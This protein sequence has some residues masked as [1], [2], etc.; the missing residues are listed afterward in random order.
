[1]VTE[2]LWADSSWDCLEY[3][4]L[5]EHFRTWY[6]KF[7]AATLEVY[8]LERPR[9]VKTVDFLRRRVI[10]FNDPILE[11]AWVEKVNSYFN[12]NTPVEVPEPIP[13]PKTKAL[14]K[15]RLH[16]SISS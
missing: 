1:M 13:G 15:T 8:G 11:A 12:D 2:D 14:L 4:S 7:D 6:Q 16:T 10:P 5:P 3:D 9:N